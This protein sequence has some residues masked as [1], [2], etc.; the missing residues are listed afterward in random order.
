MKIPLIVQI[1]E[2]SGIKRKTSGKPLK[3]PLLDTS[4]IL[5][6]KLCQ[7]KGN[8]RQNSVENYDT[9]LKMPT[10][11]GEKPSCRNLWENKVNNSTAS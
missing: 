5:L 11:W 9:N 8:L 2:I 6:P 10:F 3:C 4:S 7:N 1:R